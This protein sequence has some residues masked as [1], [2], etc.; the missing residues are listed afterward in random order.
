MSF[1]NKNLKHVFL[2]WFA[3][4]L[5][6]SSAPAYG[7]NDLELTILK[8]LSLDEL[9]DIKVTS[10]AKKEQRLFKAAS[11]IYVI[12]NEDIRRSGHTTIA[13]ALRMVPGIQVAYLD[14]NTWAV[15]SRGLNSRFASKLLVMIDG[16]SVYSQ[17]FSG[18]YW[19]EVDVAIED[20]DRI[21]VIR[22]PRGTI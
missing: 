15:T 2:L 16:R 21:E 22:G 4:V 9:L 19:D 17:I 10:V 11:T 1:N 7:K 20:I 12:T 14:A 18:T 3:W 6:S 5:M 13:E 8:D